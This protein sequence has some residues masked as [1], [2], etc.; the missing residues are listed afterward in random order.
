MPK[1]F[2]PLG[3]VLIGQLDSIIEYVSEDRP[4]DFTA[5]LGESTA[6]DRFGI[7]PK[8]ASPGISK[9]LT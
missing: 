2:R 7:R 1:K 6:V 3:K 5:C 8:A 9:E 4:W